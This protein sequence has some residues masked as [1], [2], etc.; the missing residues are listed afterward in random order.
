MANKELECPLAWGATVIK[1]MNFSNDASPVFL[2]DLHR[3]SRYKMEI[4]YFDNSY[5]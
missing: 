2:V 4:S 5:D 3:Q 1:D